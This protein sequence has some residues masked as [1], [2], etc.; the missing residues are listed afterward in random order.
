MDFS[1]TPELLISLFVLNNEI[2]GLEAQENFF[3]PLQKH[4]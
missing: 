3:E 4:P 2:R 1:D